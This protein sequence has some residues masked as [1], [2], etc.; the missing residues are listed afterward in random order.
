VDLG[1]ALTADDTVDAIFANLAVT[2][3]A[4]GGFLI[5]YPPTATSRPVTSAINFSAG[6]TIANGGFFATGISGAYHAVRIYASTTTH[7]ILDVTGFTGPASPAAVASASAKQSRVGGA[8]RS[9]ARRTVKSFSR[10]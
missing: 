8:R 10:R 7:V 6:Q 4:A 1:L 5:V 9:A 3:S 2:G